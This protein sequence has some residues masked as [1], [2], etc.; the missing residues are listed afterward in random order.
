M[1]Q[2]RQGSDRAPHAKARRRPGRGRAAPPRIAGHDGHAVRR[3]VFEAAR[4]A[5]AMGLLEPDASSRDEAAAV[6]LL[7][8]R[9]RRAGIAAAAADQLSSMPQTPLDNVEP[10]DAAAIAALLEMVIAALEASPVPEFEWAGLG[11][12]FSA[13]ELASLINVSVT[14]LKRY[15][16]GERETP[17]AVAARLHFLALVVGDLAGSYNDIGIRRWLHRRRTRLD[18]RAPVAFLKGDWDPDENGPKRIRQLASD[19]VSLSAT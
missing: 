4:R 10:P 16:S 3:L 17:D 7:A 5:E 9:V 6:R 12:F 2:V 14:S 8:A 13:E 11:R 19:L 15:V 1:Q 18:G